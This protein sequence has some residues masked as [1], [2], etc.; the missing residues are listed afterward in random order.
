MTANAFGR[1]LRRLRPSIEEKQRT[2]RRKPVWVWLGLELRTGQDGQPQDR[3]S[4]VSRD[5]RDSLLYTPRGDDQK[6]EDGRG[7]V[8][9]E[10]VEGKA[11][12]AVNAVGRANDK[13]RSSVPRSPG[14]TSPDP[15]DSFLDEDVGHE[16]G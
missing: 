15:W 11:V 1:A 2:L 3:D 12:N 14:D 9:V 7:G 10:Q 5:S 6:Q 8:G 4:L 13:P 16:P